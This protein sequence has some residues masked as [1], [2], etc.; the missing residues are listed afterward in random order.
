MS[1]NPGTRLGSYEI[2]SLLGSG[3]MGEVY[4]AKDL[5]L[6]RDVAIKVLQELLASVPERLRRFEQEASS[7]AALNHPNI[8]TIYSVEEA[9][10]IHFITMEFVEG[11][12]LAKMLPRKGFDLRWLL[13]IAI[14][15]VDAVSSAHRA[16]TQKF[17]NSRAHRAATKKFINSRRYMAST[18]AKC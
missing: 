8:I 1:L 5:K 14:P 18:V 9:D 7:A 2:T 12:T 4:R 13:E 3:G 16:G 11:Q 15:L 10:G 6:G 17:T